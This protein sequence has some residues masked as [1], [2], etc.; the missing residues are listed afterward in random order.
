MDADL[1]GR[2]NQPICGRGVARDVHHRAVGLS[3]SNPRT[4]AM[5]NRTWQMQREARAR[6]EHT[7]RVIEAGAQGGG[8]QSRYNLAYNF[9]PKIRFW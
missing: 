9:A 6:L 2:C 1:A 8:C 5:A 3:R 7:Q 4:S